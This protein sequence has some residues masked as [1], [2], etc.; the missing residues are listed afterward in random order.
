MNLRDSTRDILSQVEQLT[1]FP[2][3]VL[4]LVG[5]DD[6]ADIAYKR[7]LEIDEFGQ[8]ADLTREGRTRIAE[9]AI[10][11][12]AAGG[13]R[14]DVVWYMVSALDAFDGMTPEQVQ[15]VGFEAA[16]LGRRGLD[17]NKT[18]P[19]Y[20]LRSLPGDTA[21]STWWRSIMPRSSSLRRERT[22]PSTWRASMRQRRR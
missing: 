16:M 4:E 9:R 15:Q 8:V 19:K 5:N 18:E 14:M 17:L 13:L 6:E 10:R 2:V 21:R 3:E 20:T 1:G 12:G 7:V 11:A 22:W